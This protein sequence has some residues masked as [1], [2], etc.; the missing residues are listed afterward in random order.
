MTTGNVRAHEDSLVRELYG[1]GLSIRQIAKRTHFS[2]PKVDR[3]LA[4]IARAFGADQ[5][6]DDAPDPWDDDDDTEGTLAL[7][8]AEDVDE[9]GLQGPFRYVGTD[10]DGDRYTDANGKPCNIL[11]ICRAAHYRGEG[12]EDDDGNLV[13]TPLTAELMRQADAGTLR[14][15]CGLDYQDWYADAG[16]QATAGRNDPAMNTRL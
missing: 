9:D 14:V 12:Y 2:R 10:A 13:Y 1:Q 4:R 3:I 6:P 15:F 16:R 8:D 11:N 7:L 5:E